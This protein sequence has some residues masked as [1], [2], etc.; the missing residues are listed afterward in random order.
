[1]HHVGV[2]PTR[3]ARPLE[4]HLHLVRPTSG[5]AVAGLFLGSQELCC[6]HNPWAGLNK[7]I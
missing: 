6:I 5:L 1:M 3:P 4:A 7:P 2:G